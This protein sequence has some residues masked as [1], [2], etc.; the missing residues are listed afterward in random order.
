MRLFCK[1]IFV[2]GCR[3]IVVSG[4]ACN[5]ESLLVSGHALPDYSFQYERNS[6][7]LSCASFCLRAEVC[8]SFQLDTNTR[9]CFLN[10]KNSTSGPGI[11][12]RPG[13]IYSDINGWPKGLS[14][15]CGNH[16]CSN[17]QMCIV[18]R[19]GDTECKPVRFMDIKLNTRTSYSFIHKFRMWPWAQEYCQKEGGQLAR[20]K[21][22]EE[23]TFIG[24]MTEIFGS[25]FR[26]HWVGGVYH[27][28]DDTWRWPDGTLILYYA[29]G[30]THPRRVNGSTMTVQPNFGW[31]DEPSHYKFYFIC[32]F[33]E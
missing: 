1:V 18:P 11:Q 23:N 4:D 17:E 20:I 28:D 30:E 27:A 21:T 33:E 5:I 29:W 31:T 13:F 15:P 25:D 10:L 14:G 22:A 6:N 32:E 12:I 19:S 2:L 3:L 24:N 16:S 8:A 7:V 9:I 26:H